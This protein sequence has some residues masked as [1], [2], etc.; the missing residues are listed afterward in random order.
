MCVC[1]CAC[2]EV[3]VNPRLIYTSRCATCMDL[4]PRPLPRRFLMHDGGARH[5]CSALP[6]RTSWRGRQKSNRSGGLGAFAGRLCLRLVLKSAMA[7]A[8]SLYVE[9]GAGDAMRVNT[10]HRAK[11]GVCA[12]RC[13]MRRMRRMGRTLPLRVVAYGIYLS[14]CI[15]D[16]KPWAWPNR[17]VLCFAS[18]RARLATRS[19][20][21]L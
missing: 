8:P 9:C 10:S 13:G 5:T 11:A 12:P 19:Y 3:G 16:A 2:G 17:N 7:P 4:S 15:Y 14:I 18:A 21:L 1:A 6:K 20:I